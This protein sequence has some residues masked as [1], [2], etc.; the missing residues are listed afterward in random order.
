MQCGGVNISLYVGQKNGCETKFCSIACNVWY[1]EGGE[2][3]TV[4]LPS[5]L[6]TARH[7]SLLES[8]CRGHI[9]HWLYKVISLYHWIKKVISLYHWIYRVI[10]LSHWIYSHLGL[11]LSRAP[12]HSFTLEIPLPW[13]GILSQ[14]TFFNIPLWC[15]FWLCW[16]LEAGG[17]SSS[18]EGNIYGTASIAWKEK[19]RGRK[20]T[21][22]DT[23]GNKDW[24]DH[25]RRIE[26]RSLSRRQEEE[27]PEVSVN[28]IHPCWLQS[29][30]LGDDHCCG[31]SSVTPLP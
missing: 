10:S 30:G 4:W 23:A 21:I 5:C 20:Q 29:I 17:S 9:S 16:L 19:G 26:G 13:H 11:P 15:K 7:S 31:V 24:D 22:P 12:T 28:W 1:L 14:I 2:S 8:R 3:K 25:V 27:N 6:R 18:L